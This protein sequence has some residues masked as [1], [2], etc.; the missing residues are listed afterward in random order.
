VNFAGITSGSEAELQVVNVEGPALL[1]R[2]A[3]AAGIK[4][5]IHISSLSV[6]GRTENVSAQT[7][8]APLSAYGRSKQAGDAKLL[9]LADDNFT[10][11]VLRVPALYG[12]GV[13]DKLGLLAKALRSVRML[14]VPATSNPRVALNLQ[15][16]SIA[17]VRTIEQRLSGLWFAADP[18]PF[19]LAALADVVAERSGRRVRLVGVPDILF[20]PLRLALPGL[21]WSLYG[22]S[23]IKSEDCVPLDPSQAKPTS[24]ALADLLV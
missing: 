9:A 14:P 23:V 22:R 3:K 19:T 8:E 18:E 6:Y 5:Y 2:A 10:V 21:Y 17:I 16:M 24:A 11:T 12:P 7:P 13:G 4:H 20:L 15:N 1:A